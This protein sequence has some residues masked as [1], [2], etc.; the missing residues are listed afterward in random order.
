MIIPGVNVLLNAYNPC[1]Q[2]HVNCRNWWERTL[3]GTEVV[4]LSWITIAVAHVRNWLKQPSVTIVHP[5]DMHAEI[6]FSL[7]EEVGVAGNLTSDAHLA[8]LAMEHR[9]VLA[10]TDNDFARFKGLRWINPASPKR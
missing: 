8:A 9:A 7:I 4:G 3:S 2:V 1:S 10:S 6:L 5:S